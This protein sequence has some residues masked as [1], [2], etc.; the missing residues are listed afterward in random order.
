[1]Q[2][3]VGKVKNHHLGASNQYVSVDVFA[4]LVR[5]VF[6]V[7]ALL[8]AACSFH[9]P[10]CVASAVSATSVSSFILIDVYHDSINFGTK[11][12][13]PAR[14]AVGGKRPFA[15]RLR[16][17]GICC[18]SR[19]NAFRKP[20]FCPILFRHLLSFVARTIFVNFIRCIRTFIRRWD[21]FLST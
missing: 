16:S 13:I 8:G 20:P 11:G 7:R 21:P 10:S 19:R 12:T 1:M 5:A 17:L 4:S 6:Y 9:V 18:R 14:T 2:L 3:R 15:I